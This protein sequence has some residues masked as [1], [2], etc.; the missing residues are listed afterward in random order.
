MWQNQNNFWVRQV[1]LNCG[2]LFCPKEKSEIEIVNNAYG[3]IVSR[4]KYKRCKI[5]INETIR[6]NFGWACRKE[7]L[8]VEK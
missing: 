6:N 3:E 5:L 7:G 4:S 8:I 1:R 2:R